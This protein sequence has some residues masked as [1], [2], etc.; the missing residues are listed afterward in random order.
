MKTCLY[1]A[2][3][4]NYETLKDPVKIDGLDYI[5]FTD[6]KTITSNVWEIRYIESPLDVPPSLFYK[7]IKCLS[8]EYLPNY[9]ITIWLDANFVVKDKEY[10]TTL[11]KS[12]KSNKIIVYKHICLAGR[13]R[14]CAYDEGRYSMTIPKYGKEK[15]NSQL[16]EYEHLHEFPKHNGLYQSGFIMRNNR[17]SDVIKFN[18]FWLEQIEKFGRVYPQCQV[19]LA[20]TLWKLGLT[21]DTIDNIWDTNVYGI[22]F[23]GNNNKFTPAY[24]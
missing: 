6:N 4:G 21:F 5:C 12:F 1:T 17:D 11:M 13:P 18:E 24:T 19:S 20:F 22:T 8:H 9:D 16:N 14:D 15:I 2:I 23:H 3:F 10:L 7:K